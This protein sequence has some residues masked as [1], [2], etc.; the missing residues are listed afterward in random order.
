MNPEKKKHHLLKQSFYFICFAI[1]IVAFVVLGTR[2]YSVKEIADNELFAKEY[3][4]I[5][6]NNQF[7]VLNS[8]E[9]LNLL[10][11]GTG[12]LFLGFPSNE[13]SV[14]IAEILHEVSQQTNYPISYYNFYADRE[15]RHDNYQGIIRELDGYLLQ[16]DLGKVEVHAPSVVAVVRGEVIFFDDETSFM[17]HKEAPRSYWTLEKRLSKLIEYQDIIERLKKEK[18]L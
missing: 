11:R 17:N 3:R 7:H 4:T 9:T 6:N 8:Y 2:N 1:L 18:K 12:L 10:E 15:K 13:W 14:P 16:D 5:P